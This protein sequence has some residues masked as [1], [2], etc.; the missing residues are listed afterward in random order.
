MYNPLRLI[1]PSGDTVKL[2]EGFFFERLSER[3]KVE[4][5]NCAFEASRSR[6]AEIKDVFERPADMFPDFE[7]KGFGSRLHVLVI[8][9]YRAQYKSDSDLYQVLDAFQTVFIRNMFKLIIAKRVIFLA[10]AFLM[11][12]LVYGLHGGDGVIRVFFN[13]DTLTTLS[14][15]MAISL[16]FFII[17]N[18]AVHA[19]YKINFKL[20]CPRLSNAAQTRFS[21]INSCFQQAVSALDSDEQQC[22]QAEWP[23]RSK[24][25]TIMILWYSRRVEHIE[26]YFQATMWRIRRMNFFTDIW[27]GLSVLLA[28]SIA[29]LMTYYMSQLGREDANSYETTELIFFGV[30]YFVIG[31]MSFVLWDID[32]GMLKKNIKPRDWARFYRLKLHEELGDAIYRSR[33]RIIDEK[34]RQRSSA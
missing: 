12:Y 9:G 11:S 23:D 15:A 10:S 19:W 27:G 5:E 32:I 30:F 4:R 29:V 8:K 17:V 1:F 33:R 18:G 24:W 34:N 26:K 21:D 31:L 16:A 22:S 6:E 14:L 2:N 3:C 7:E 20:S 28:L 13:T 25:W